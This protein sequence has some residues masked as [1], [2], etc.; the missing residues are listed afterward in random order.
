MAQDEIFALRYDPRCQPCWDVVANL[1]GY[2]VFVGT[3]NSVSLYAEGVP[4]SRVIV[5]TGSVVEVGMRH[6]L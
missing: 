1:V 4:D 2:S 3:K 6:G 5:C